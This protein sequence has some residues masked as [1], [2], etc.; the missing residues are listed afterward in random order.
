MKIK[1]VPSSDSFDLA[2]PNL[3]RKHFFPRQRLRITEVAPIVGLSR[4][5]LYKRI[6]ANRL[7]LKIQYD[8]AGLPFVT[9]EDLI[10]YLYPA[11][12]SQPSPSSDPIRK[13]GRPRKTTDGVSK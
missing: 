1:P 10:S 12:P 4:D 7:N 13:R 2:A 3:L 5:R 8:E 9:V 6:K 11:H